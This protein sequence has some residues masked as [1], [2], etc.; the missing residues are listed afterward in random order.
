MRSDPH[1]ASTCS[2]WRKQQIHLSN[3][4]RLLLTLCCVSV[5]C[6]L[7]VKK[8]DL[9]QKRNYEILHKWYRTWFSFSKGTFHSKKKNSV[10]I[11][12]PL[13]WWKVEGSLIVHSCGAYFSETTETD[14][15]LFYN[16]KIHETA[17]HRL[18]SFSLWKPKL[19]LAANLKMSAATFLRCVQ[20][21]SCVETFILESWITSDKLL[22]FKV[23][24]PQLHQL[25]WTTEPQPT[26]TSVTR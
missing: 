23:V 16:I 7:T 11:C 20:R 2:T 9:F 12:S 15:D 22:F 5:R 1:T 26:F 3:L 13:H 14:G 25:M 19:I 4:I 8:K 21:R 18:F 24:S 10:I 6:N 17:P